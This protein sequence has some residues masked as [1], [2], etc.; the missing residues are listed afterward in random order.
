MET[1]IA[2]IA[3][4]AAS[5]VV[6]CCCGPLVADTFPVVDTGQALCYDA[7]GTMAAPLPGR[8]FYGQDAQ[9]TRNRPSYTLSPDGLTV[10][11]DN[12]RLTWLKSPVVRGHGHHR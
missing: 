6:G 3:C 2:L 5:L 7:A 10:R 11:D 9:Y 1:R 4:L 8:A 12:T